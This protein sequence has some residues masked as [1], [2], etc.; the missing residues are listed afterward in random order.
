MK[1][2]QVLLTAA[3]GAYALCAAN[4][5]EPLIR[6]QWSGAEP[7]VWTMDYKT[8]LVNAKT[9][10][11]WT[12]MYYSGMW[13]CPHCQP[14]E[15]KVLVGEP[16]REYVEENG[17]YLTVLDF[18]NRAGTGYWCWLWDPGYRE[19]AGLTPE[20]ATEALI[21]RFKVQDK[22]ALATGMVTTNANTV[23]TVEDGGATT[24]KVPYEIEPT[25]V[26]KR[27]GYPSF[28]VINPKGCVIGRFSAS[29]DTQTPE[30]AFAVITNRIEQA[31]LGGSVT[32]GVESGEENRGTAT[33]FDGVLKYGETL[34]LTA[35]A[36]KG[37]AFA[38]WREGGE[39]SEDT[40]LDYRRAGNT[41]VASGADTDLRAHFAAAS[42][43]RLSFD[44][45]TDL[46]FFYAGEEV[47]YDL[48][49]DSET[50]PTVRMSGLPDG[51]SF[52]AEKL[53]VVGAAKTPGTYVVTAT[54]KNAWGYTFTQT[55]TAFVDN[56]VGE[57]F[58]GNDQECEL[59]EAFEAKV[60]DLFDVSDGYTL[61]GVRLSG[62]PKGLVQSAD[63][64]TVS[65]KPTVAGTSVVTGVGTF[66]DGTQET[67]TFFFDVFVPE[68]P[69]EAFVFFDALED[70]S[71]ATAVTADDL[72]LGF[73]EDGEGVTAISG[74]PSG[75]RS[76]TWAEDGVKWFGAAGTPDKAGP[77]TVTATVKYRNDAGRTVTEKIS[78]TFVVADA[79]C[80]YIG[81][82]L[83]AATNCPGCTATGGGVT[84]PGQS[85]KLTAKAA[86][87]FVFAG[88]HATEDEPVANDG[89]TDYR[90]ATRTVVWADDVLNVWY[91]KFVTKAEDVDHGVTI[92]GLDG[93][94]FALDAAEEFDETFTVDSLSLP[95]L[96]AK[97]LPDGVTCDLVSDGEG[98][99]HLRFDPLTAKK[100]PAPGRY[101]VTVTVSNQSKA[102]ATA[103]F[104]IVVANWTDDNIL[105]KD[106]YGIYKPGVA[107]SVDA[108]VNP[109]IFL[110]N[111]VDFAR[112]DTLKVSGLPKGLVYNDK[113]DA[114]KGVVARTITGTP[115]V[116]GFYTLTF[117]AKVLGKTHQ[118][119]SSLTVEDFPALNVVVSEEAAAAGN[120]VTGNK[121]ATYIAGSK[122]TLK[123][124]AAAGWVFASWE[125]DVDVTGRDA[126]NPTLVYVTGADPSTVVAKF[127]R[128]SEDN[129]YVCGLAEL[130]TVG[131][132]VHLISRGA[133]LADTVC[134]DLVE[135]AL[136]SVS[137]P[138]VSV[139]G[140]PKGAKFSAKTLELSGKV[141]TPGHSYVTVSA[142]N[143]GGY[144][145]VR[146]W[147]FCVLNA[148]GSAPEEPTEVNTAQAEFSGFDGLVTG[149]HCESG[150]VG[151]VVPAHESTDSA[152]TKVAVKGL[153]SGLVATTALLED[154]G[155]EVR[156]SGTP[157]KPGRF[158]LEAT[159]TYASKKT[160]KAVLSFVVA[161]GGSAYLEV[162]SADAACGTVTG[163]GV[164]ASGQTVKLK[165]TAKAKCVFGGWY[166]PPA[167]EALF[168]EVFDLLG[169]I[170]GI[171]YRTPGVSFPFRPS[172]MKSLTLEAE[173]ASAEEDILMSVVPEGEVWEIDAAAGSAFG[174]ALE[175]YS[176]PKVT[177]KGLPAG[178]AWNAGLEAFVYD[179]ANAAKLVPGV[180]T[181]TVSAVNQSKKSDSASF[182]LT[183]PN[184][185]SEYIGGLE[186]DPFAYSFST[187][188]A[189][190][191]KAIVP[192]VDEGW[193]LAVSGLPQGLSWK[194]GEIVGV[195]TK[196]GYYT[197]T[198]TATTGK[199]ASKQTE[200]ATIVIGIVALPQDA[201]GSFVGD[202]FCS[203]YDVETEEFTDAL[204][205]TLSVS[206]TSAGKISATV[207]RP[208]GTEKFSA[209]V[210]D[211]LD[212]DSGHASVVLKKGTTSLALGL[213]FSGAWSNR[214]LS[215][216]Y[217]AGETVR[218]GSALRNSFKDDAEAAEAL[219]PLVGTYG[220]KAVIV[221]G[222]ETWELEEAASHP[223]LNVT[224]KSDGVVTFAGTVG[225][226]K[227]SGTTQMSYQDGFVV[228]Q[229][230]MVGGDSTLAIT[231]RF[232][233]DGEFL[234]GDAVLVETDCRDCGK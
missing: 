3:L 227:V 107:L 128:L 208:T 17:Y 173:F 210:W 104:A 182:L 92:G 184:L 32:V 181:V 61:E 12:I 11:K 171:D 28:L 153:P 63:G 81:A 218:Y 165:A 213:D 82:A 197:V 43:D 6:P 55:W 93:V 100:T 178:I 137:L 161:D 119:T 231:L 51:L 49:V 200:K 163:A 134:R 67:A 38:G 84:E 214:V 108:E 123:A 172:E 52:D 220:F 80:R 204:A 186:S 31:K 87:G 233:D 121:S 132:N 10:D 20:A 42:E 156:C 21:E 109:T 206:V 205:G 175:S 69:A 56:I 86:A 4:V 159:V 126:Q 169:D 199:G 102:S 190:D 101:A 115:T 8:A 180:Y 68:S 149:E 26:Y 187:G 77:F 96:T 174:V 27:I 1:K 234:S 15:E 144:S 131:T 212:L 170:D 145:F 179:T 148:D 176:L 62:L 150:A 124:V 78:R 54:A 116:P 105:V 224:V 41:F 53:C 226:Y 225:G 29:V 23:V 167:E 40:V 35:T 229:A 160:S 110:T 33:K 36:E 154:G 223:T 222:G 140:L 90:V 58:H 191:P 164:Y 142:S 103:V 221:E 129:L 9:A 193:S 207:V 83:L 194:N 125:G 106:D 50:F 94:E 117:T 97:G 111:A 158:T 72:E 30:E 85:V 130:E 230:T 70:L 7:G 48:L 202:L 45:S 195:P 188:A 168:G 75:L 133:D 73:F 162:V 166:Y 141:T 22:Y 39:A 120:K 139:A 14:L 71:V 60:S 79:E 217:S 13:W 209:N 99:Y 46:S 118:A 183:L 2:M 152:V 122:V 5:R 44:F 185:E 24:N 151:I 211:A 37:Y 127:V 201:A 215:A 203:L 216:D 113:A 232:G 146:V 16:W 157:A 47:E 136:E 95:T 135:A 89:V 177:I 198:F 34:S 189:F 196:A 66:A 59:G 228:R 25:T 219:K 138:T 91:A 143:A 64:K 19:D 18:P 65:G 155:A 98:E 88:W 112:G 147:H 76:V 114:K 192:E 74:L 57:R